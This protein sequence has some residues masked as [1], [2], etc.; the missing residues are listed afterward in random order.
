MRTVKLKTL[1]EGLAFNIADITENLEVD[2]DEYVKKYWE[3]I[4]NCESKI[5]ELK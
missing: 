3:Y 1:L 4:K 2:S 5:E